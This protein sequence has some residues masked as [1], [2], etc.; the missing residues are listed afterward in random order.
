MLTNV[1]SHLDLDKVLKRDLVNTEYGDLYDFPV[2]IKDSLDYEDKLSIIESL[3]FKVV[4]E[5][6]SYRLI[7][8]QG[9]NL[10]NIENETFENLDKILDRLDLYL[11]DYQICLLSR[12]EYLELKK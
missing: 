3:D 5:N 6:G 8:L 9:A 1:F 2:Y 7:D 12:E 11:Y 10:A 4:K